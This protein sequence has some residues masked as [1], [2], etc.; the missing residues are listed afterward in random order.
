MFANN[1]TLAAAVSTAAPSTP[2]APA[3]PAGRSKLEARFAAMLDS[4]DVDGEIQD[5][6]GT[7]GLTKL[8]LFTSLGKHFG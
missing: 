3:A 7:I 6:L 2:T 1:S 8:A 4:A 5:K